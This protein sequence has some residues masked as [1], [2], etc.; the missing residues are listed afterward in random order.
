[1]ASTR[2][3]V[4]ADDLGVLVLRKPKK[5]TKTVVRTQQGVPSQGLELICRLA[6]PLR[7]PWIADGRE[8]KPHEIK[9]AIRATTVLHASQ[10]LQTE[11]RGYGKV[12]EKRLEE[13]L[14]NMGYSK[15]RS[16]KK[17]HVTSPNDSPQPKTFYG[18]CTV[19]GRKADL[20]IGVADG[21]SV[22]VEAKE[23]AS[24]LNSVKRVLHDTAAK[25]EHWKV[26]AGTTIVPVALLSGVFGLDNLK[27]ALDHGLYLVWA[28]NLASFTGWLDAHE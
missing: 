1:M 27:S 28:H 18:E 26:K 2:P 4:S 9:T 5:L 12:L 24:V 14:A 7:F 25:A 10:T 3:L 20:L 13:H 6:D 17:G 16:P 11:R 15:V 8:P 19:Y 23:S 21:R 22:A